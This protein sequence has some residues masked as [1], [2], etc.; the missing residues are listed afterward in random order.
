LL[1]TDSEKSWTARSRKIFPFSPT[2]QPNSSLAVCCEAL[3]PAQSRTTVSVQV[4][5]GGFKTMT[6]LDQLRNPCAQPGSS[7][8]PR[9]RTSS[10]R[11]VRPDQRL[12]NE[13]YGVWTPAC[14]RT[15]TTMKSAPS[16]VERVGSR[17][18]DRARVLSPTRS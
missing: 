10:A 13:R 18:A 12:E 17:T 5:S 1:R 15:T 11:L 6:A 9:Q 4:L 8:C 14:A 7:L 3:G 16:K 2:T